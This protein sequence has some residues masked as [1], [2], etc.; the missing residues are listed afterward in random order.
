M[1]Q[2]KEAKM[3]LS[4]EEFGPFW[5]FLE[6]DTITD[7][8][9]QG[10]T[11]WITDLKAGVYKVT[12][13]D[14]LKDFTREFIDLFTRMIA[15]HVNR[16][17][18]RGPGNNVL[19]AETDELRIEIMHESV[20]NS[21]RSICIRKSPPKVRNTIETSI[22]SRYMQPEAISFLIN[23]VI[24]RFS[25]AYCGEPGVGKTELLKFLSQFIAKNQKVITIEDNPEIHYGD[26]N[27][28]ALYQ[29]LKIDGE[30][31]SYT[32]AIKSCLRLNPKWIILSEA[33]S[34][35]VKYLLEAWSTGVSGMTTLHTDDVRKIPERIKNMMGSDLDSDRMDN[36]I[37]ESLKIGALLRQKYD[38]FRKENYRYVDQIGLFY[39]DGDENRMQ[40]I[41]KD[42]EL[43]SKQVP[44]TIARMMERYDIEDPFKNDLVTEAL[45]NIEAKEREEA[46]EDMEIER[47]AYLEDDDPELDE[48]ERDYAGVEDENNSELEKNINYTCD[49][50]EESGIETEHSLNAEDLPLDGDSSMNI[51]D[52]E[53]DNSFSEEDALNEDVVTQSESELNESVDIQEDHNDILKSGDGVEEAESSSFPN[54]YVKPGRKKKKN[55]FRKR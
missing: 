45:H 42:G 50:E 6:K 23:C 9:F 1:A 3:E 29:E 10:S 18:N 44:R 13:P 34:R 32:T 16:S 55:R 26:I 33:R 51:E 24:S 5:Q 4:K 38:P 30:R 12:D 39:R 28:G 25:M 27:P 31:F 19:E 2:I 49:I 43:V 54:D 41:V 36:S 53:M 47:G 21:G 40:F 37:Y 52:E 17:F 15:D 8:D 22:T 48:Y 46:E 14:I 20:A 7:I 11:L 35:E